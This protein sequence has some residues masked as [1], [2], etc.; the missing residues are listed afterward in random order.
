MVRTCLAWL[1]LAGPLALAA[2]GGGDDDAAPD[3]RP[4]VDAEPGTPDARVPR[5]VFGGDRPVT[6]RVP[7]GYVEGTPTPLVL[8]LHGYSVDGEFMEGYTGFGTLF[9]TEGFLLA[10]PNG[11][12]DEG[13][14][15]FWNG[16]DAC[17]DLFGSGVDDEAYLLDILDEIA[18]DYTVDPD[19]VYLIGFSNGGFMSYRLA[20]H[21][22]DRFAA[23]VSLAGAT[24]DDALDCTPSAPVS[25]LQVHGT[26]D[27]TIQYDGGT[28]DVEGAPVTYPSAQGT[29]ERWSTS[30]GCTGSGAGTARDL[31]GSLAGDETA[32]LDATGC[33][34][35]VD[36]ALRTVTGGSHV[37][38]LSPDARASLWAW[39]EAH[40]R[41]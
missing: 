7:T 28:I 6:L 36:V 21:H 22:A 12:I 32:V 18:L 34:A 31:V 11:T 16:T 25:V 15:R 14:D 20:C 19:R 13:G 27:P 38:P 1:G 37:L 41:P 23:V 33:P 30:N 29:V 40:P 4:A 9:E 26:V 10:A 35:G 17:C 39:L 8:A 24:Y 5:T 2:C 3:A